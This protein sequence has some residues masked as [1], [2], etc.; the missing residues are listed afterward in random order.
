MEDFYSF[1]FTLRL[2][3]VTQVMTREKEERT[4]PCPSKNLEV[5]EV[6]LVHNTNNISGGNTSQENS[7]RG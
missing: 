5:K 3:L 1:G 4:G 6:F 7:E 2:L